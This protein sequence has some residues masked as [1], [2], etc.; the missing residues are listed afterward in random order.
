MSREWVDDH[1]PP[2]R[3]G[4]DTRDK[5]WVMRCDRNIFGPD[6]RCTTVSEPSTTEPPLAPFIDQGWHIAARFGDI[7][8]D[9]LAA[10]HHPTSEPHPLMDSTRSVGA[11][12]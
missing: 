1:K 3:R 2:P 9:C 11:H 4:P 6:P 7:C 5:R 8:P 10:G 12:Q